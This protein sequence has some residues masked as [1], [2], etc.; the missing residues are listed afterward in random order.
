MLDVRRTGLSADAFARALLA[1]EGVCV[2]AGDAFGG[3]AA[4][5]VR[6]SLTA[7]DERLAEACNR[8]GRFAFRQSAQA[9]SGK[10]A[11]TLAQA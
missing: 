7:P 10:P 9:R 3:A 8:I 6:L 11:L 4:G 1:S 5:H 2:L